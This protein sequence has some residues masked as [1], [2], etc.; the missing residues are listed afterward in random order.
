MNRNINIWYAGYLIGNPRRGQDS[1]V[2][3]PRSRETWINTSSERKTGI[4]ERGNQGRESLIS[5]CF[6]WA[7][8]FQKV[9]PSYVFNMWTFLPLKSPTPHPRSSNKSCVNSPCR[10]W[11]ILDHILPWDPSL[12]PGIWD[13]YQPYS[14]QKQRPELCIFNYWEELKRWSWGGGRSPKEGYQAAWTKSSPE[15]ECSNFGPSVTCHQDPQQTPIGSLPLEWPQA[16]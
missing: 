15:L 11:S 8:I 14:G 10:N 9:S 4:R 2:E 13:A 7:S 6:L 12:R 5:N 3:N 1:Q 16:V